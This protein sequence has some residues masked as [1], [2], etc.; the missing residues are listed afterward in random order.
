VED[1]GELSDSTRRRFQNRFAKVPLAKSH[2]R[3]VATAFAKFESYMLDVQQQTDADRAEIDGLRADGWN[4]NEESPMAQSSASLGK[5]R[6][7]RLGR[8][9]P[10]M[11]K[12]TRDD[13]Y[14]DDGSNHDSGSSSDEGLEDLPLRGV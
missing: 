14:K 7:L 12:K 11:K 3:Q 4:P 1:E 9:N 6:G 13:S 8:V 5:A 2:F 10:A